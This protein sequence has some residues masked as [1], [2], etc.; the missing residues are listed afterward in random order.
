M[1]V[2]RDALRPLVPAAE[3]AAIDGLT[4]A[5]RIE[6]LIRFGELEAAAVD[7]LFP[8]VDGVHPTADAFRTV[9]EAMAAWALEGGPRPRAAALATAALPGRV[10]AKTHEGFAWYALHP[11]AH[12]A[13]ARTLAADG[14]VRSAVVV[15]LRGIGTTL[16]SI[17]T[18]TLRAEGVTT[19]SVTLRPRGHPFDRRAAVDAALARRIVADP[20][21]TVVVV[22]EGPG[23]SGSS[24]C[25]TAAALSDLG[26]PDGRIVLSPAWIPDG[27]SFASAAARDRWARHRK[28]AAP[29]DRSWFGVPAT[30]VDR[31]GGAWRP[32]ALP[33]P[34]DWPPVH[35]QQSP[36]TFLSDGR[37]LRFTGFA[38]TGRAVAGTARRLA[39]AGLGPPVLDHAAGTTVFGWIAG[40]P[41][42]P[43][44]RSRAVLL[45]MA[46]HL[47][48]RAQ[49]HRTGAGVDADALLDLIRA[50]ATAIHGPHP[51]LG[52]LDR[53][54]PLLADGPAVA[55]DGRMDPHR[56]LDTGSGLVK[57]GG[58]ERHAGHLQPG[59]TDPAWDVA[60]L[61]AGFALDETTTADLAAAVAARTGDRTLVRRLAP[62][63]AAVLGFRA[64][65]A[66]L[67]ALALGGTPEAERFA[68]RE[69]E[70]RRGLAAALDRLAA[71]GPF[72]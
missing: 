55:I 65:H 52:T 32:A 72:S 21:A 15:G 25:G 16:A 22:D 13:A 46:D 3:L 27:R 4:A 66:R 48:H 69:A 45:R 17:V 47:V 68:R 9:G 58:A 70:A 42:R 8:A 50:N 49:A 57:T 11:R 60:D 40:R 20:E 61:A 35:P 64:A 34:A 56:W 53:W 24:L 30:A 51:A 71:P 41:L 10:V 5:D 67:A 23:L 33:D 63:T 2:Y 19:L 36:P 44:D 38:A 31:T 18:A 29:F 54:R 39:D 1:K 43:G 26:V 59:P 28:L 37:L 6:A 62:V 7:A 12:A 14:G